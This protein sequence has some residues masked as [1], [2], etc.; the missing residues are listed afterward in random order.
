MGNGQPNTGLLRG[1]LHRTVVYLGRKL[2]CEYYLNLGMKIVTNKNR[3]PNEKQKLKC[4]LN[5]VMKLNTKYIMKHGM[6]W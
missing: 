6:L 4:N 3:Q 5:S 1:L 2:V